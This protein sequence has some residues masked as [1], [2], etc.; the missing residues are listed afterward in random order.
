[1][2][3]T[4]SLLFLCGIIQDIAIPR[5]GHLRQLITSSFNILVGVSMASTHFSGPIVST[6]GFTGDITG[7]VTGN[8]SGNQ[9]GGSVAATT[10][11]ASSTAQITGLLTATAGLK[12]GTSSVKLTQVYSG[13]VAVDPGSL[14]TLTSTDVSVTITGAATGDIVIVNPPSTLESTLACGGA[15]VSAADTVKIR[16]SNVSSGTVDGASLTW[17]YAILRFAAA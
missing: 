9:S 13:T 1:M 14:T 5:L 6:N 7:N 12:P 10:I 2:V 15:Y 8:I 17:S 3:K 11:T 4:S 16:V